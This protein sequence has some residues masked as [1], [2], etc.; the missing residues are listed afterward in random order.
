ME[1]ISNVSLVTKKQKYPPVLPETR[2]AADILRFWGA[3]GQSDSSDINMLKKDSPKLE[4]KSVESVM[5][6]IGVGFTSLRLHSI[7]IGISGSL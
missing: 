7:G 3:R 4:Q 6:G 5:R 1:G 2:M